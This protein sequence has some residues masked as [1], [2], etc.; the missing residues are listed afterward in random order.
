MPASDSQPCTKMKIMVNQLLTLSYCQKLDDNDKEANLPPIAVNASTANSY[1]VFQKRLVSSKGI[2]EEHVT[3]L[4]RLENTFFANVL[5]FTALDTPPPSR[6]TT[7]LR[8]SSPSRRIL[9][10]V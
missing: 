2:G 1:V 4:K 8:P 6:S 3:T 10:H 5:R 7:H 9:S